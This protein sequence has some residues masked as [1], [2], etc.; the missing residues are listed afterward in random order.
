MTNAQYMTLSKAIMDRG[1]C[2]VGDN[3]EDGI[4]RLVHVKEGFTDEEVAQR[5]RELKAMVGVF[6]F[7]NGCVED[8]R[9][10]YKLVERP[11]FDNMIAKLLKTFG[12]NSS[13]AADISAKLLE[14]VR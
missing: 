11:M 12:I 9:I 7:Q 13:I 2:P 14:E 5:A 1:F 3:C 6:G 4:L 10:A 8:L